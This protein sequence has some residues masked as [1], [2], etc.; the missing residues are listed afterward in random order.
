MTIKSALSVVALAAGL[1]A[2]PTFAQSSM[3]IGTQTVAETDVEAVK[4]RC[5]DLKRADETQS[6]SETKD[7]D[8]ADDDAASDEETA[9]DSVAGD[10]DIVD[11][12]AT[13][14]ETA[15]SV[16]LGIIT[17]E[18]CEAGGWFDM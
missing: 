12:P 18:E 16:D 5:D 14:S 17:L 8:D 13:D 11:V 7:A 2:A 9:D 3:M 15:T 4:A 1:V 6:L 10:A